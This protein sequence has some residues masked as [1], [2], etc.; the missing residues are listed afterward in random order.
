MGIVKIT[1]PTTMSNHHV[2]LDFIFFPSFF[3][4][5]CCILP[6]FFLLRHIIPHFSSQLLS[7][8]YHACIFFALMDYE[9][10]TLTTVTSYI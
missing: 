10:S 9:S 3:S 7:S 8:Y 6:V 5:F 2:D 4:R 1:I